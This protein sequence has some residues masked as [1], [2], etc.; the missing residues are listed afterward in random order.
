MSKKDWLSKLFED[1]GPVGGGAGNGTSADLGEPPVYGV[2]SKKTDNDDAEEEAERRKS[3]VRP[4][5]F[6]AMRMKKSKRRRAGT[7]PKPSSRGAKDTF[8]AGTIPTPKRGSESF[9][10]SAFI[11]PF[12]INESVSHIRPETLTIKGGYD[13][14]TLVSEDGHKCLRGVVRDRLRNILGMLE[15]KTDLSL[16]INAGGIGLI[17]AP[18]FDATVYIPESS[19]TKLSS[20]WEE[21][22]PERE[23]SVEEPSV[24]IGVLTV[25]HGVFVLS[26]TLTMGGSKKEYVF[27]GT[28]S[29][30]NAILTILGATVRGAAEHP[31]VKGGTPK[32]AISLAKTAGDEV[33]VVISL[34]RLL[35]IGKPYASQIL[36]WQ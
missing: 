29:R 7:D 16:D 31:E 28:D 36:T 33:S 27:T 2:S 11:S 26:V 22:E 15:A 23:G 34:D 21:D 14:F 24:I 3:K 10:R 6:Q 1:A 18:W 9:L 5:T 12:G 17:A 30:M 19:R 8:F 4:P 32:D 20:I 13:G 25:D 35:S